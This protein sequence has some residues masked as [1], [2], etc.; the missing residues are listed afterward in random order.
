MRVLVIGAGGHGMVVADI[1]MRAFDKGAQ[2]EPIGYLDDKPA[3][4]GILILGLP[5]LGTLAE[6]TE[7]PHDAV[8]FAIGDN[9][10]RKRLFLQ[11]RQAGETTITA[12]HPAAIL[13]PSARIGTGT[14]ICASAVI[15][16][17]TVIGENV[18]VNT[19]SVVDHENIV[20]DHA[21]V[22]GGVNMT[23][24]IHIGEGAFI[25][26]GATILPGIQV[27]AWSIVG[28]GTLVH[29]DIPERVT[30]VGLPGRIVGREEAA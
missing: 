24:N 9:A 19:N 26:T 18:I 12:I 2:V 13:A 4:Q 15:G 22:S 17:N 10:T 16:V 8:I 25:G 7:I 6:H 5:V 11:F 27:G 1:L 14:V 29:D 21:H 28:A 23:G 30:V 20:E 3:L